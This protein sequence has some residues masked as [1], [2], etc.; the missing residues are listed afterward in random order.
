[1]E[2]GGHI[3]RHARTDAYSRAIQL[4]FSSYADR[5]QRDPHFRAQQ[6]SHQKSISWGIETITPAEKAEA[7]RRHKA[8]TAAAMA[9]AAEQRGTDWDA[10]STWRP[11]SQSSSAAQPHAMAAPAVPHQDKGAGKG[12]S[13]FRG[14]YGGGPYS[15]YGKGKDHEKGKPKGGERKGKGKYRVDME[16]AFVLLPAVALCLPGADAV[17]IAGV[18]STI[19]STTSSPRSASPG[20]ESSLLFYAL[21]SVAVAFGMSFA[22]ICTQCFWAV[23]RFVRESPS[24]WYKPNRWC[25]ARQRRVTFENPVFPR[26]EVPMTT[27]LPST[28]SEEFETNLAQLLNSWVSERGDRY[29]S[30]EFCWGLRAATTR[31]TERSPCQFCHHFHGDAPIRARTPP[32]TPR[33]IGGYNFHPSVNAANRHR[34]AH[35]SPHRARNFVHAEPMPKAKARARNHHRNNREGGPGGVA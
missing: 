10:W 13:T 5:Y 4:G 19:A 6:I 34:H 12:Q 11:S 18:L 17:R 30:D 14:G 8:R 24:D 35:S 32:T 31:V 23:L 16:N 33:G 26:F 15:S 27:R 25:T 28:S 22:I 21:I 20:D 3:V 1:M 9:A 7:E 29:H 2:K